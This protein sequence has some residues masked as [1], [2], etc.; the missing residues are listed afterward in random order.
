MLTLNTDYVTQRENSAPNSLTTV[1]HSGIFAGFY[2]FSP[3]APLPNCPLPPPDDPVGD[4]LCY[5]SD[6]IVGPEADWSGLSSQSDLDNWGV[7]LTIDW[8][9]RSKCRRP[10]SR[11]MGCITG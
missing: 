8:E 3:N 1:N 10:R 2:N 6:W 7:G 11:R 5:S 9:R 4:P